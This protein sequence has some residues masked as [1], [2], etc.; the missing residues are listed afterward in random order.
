MTV[1][2]NLTESDIREAPRFLLSCESCPLA[3][4]ISRAIGEPCWVGIVDWGSSSSPRWG[5]LPKIAHDFRRQFDGKGP[6]PKPISFE[7]D[8]EDQT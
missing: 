4:A 7:I 5:F 6:L 2:V 3:V 8:V 1:T